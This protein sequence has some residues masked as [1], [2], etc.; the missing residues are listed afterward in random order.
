MTTEDLEALANAGMDVPSAKERFMNNDALLEKFVKKFPEDASYKKLL[1]GVAN[2]DLDT[3]FMSAHT[4]K[5]VAAN[6]SFVKLGK[7]VSD[8]TE[9]F[10]AGRLDAGIEMMPQ[11]TE[12]YDKI[13]K[14]IKELFL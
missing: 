12:E 8:Q 4:L 7:L 5:G 14:V 9:E 6:F 10:R 3:C 11:I 13:V 2:R 1:E